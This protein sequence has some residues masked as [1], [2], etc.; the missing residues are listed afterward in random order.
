MKEN[1]L[2]VFVAVIAVL[3]SLLAA[4]LTYLSISSLISQIS[5]YVTTGEANLT[6]ETLAIINFT[7]RNISWGSGKVHSDVSSASLTTFGTLPNVTGGNFTLSTAGGLRVENIGNVN[8]SLN[9]TGGK[10]AA[11]FIGGTN[12]VYKWNITSSEAGSCVNKTGTGEGA[13]NLNTFHNVNTTLA[14][15]LKCFTLRFES[16]N[17]EIR[18]D[19]NL[20][21]PD[22]SATGA[23]GDVLTATVY[24]QNP[25]GA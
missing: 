6:V 23:L 14:D 2:I 5:G 18:I 24:A 21:I 10:T 7:T 16:A 8:V 1:N 19:F 12:P 13:L 11:Q 15:S 20:T 17:D 9:L 25:T 22:D 3:I 4:G